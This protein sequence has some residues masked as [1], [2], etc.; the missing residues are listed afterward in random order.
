MAWLINL[1]NCEKS[2]TMYQDSLS[3][4][5]VKMLVMMFPILTVEEMTSSADDRGGWAL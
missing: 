4:V 3:T 5:S 2:L 1:F